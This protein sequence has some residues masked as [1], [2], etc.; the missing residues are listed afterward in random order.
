MTKFRL[1][2]CLIKSLGVP[3]DFA[4]FRHNVFYLLGRPKAAAWRRNPQ[5]IG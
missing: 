1:Y 2:N 3:A 4:S 5:G